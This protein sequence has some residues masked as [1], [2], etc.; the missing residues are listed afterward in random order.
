LGATAPV[1]RASARQRIALDALTPKRAAARRHDIPPSTAAITR[2]RKS[3]DGA[4]AMPVGLP[5]RQAA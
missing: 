2:S 4:F 1:S 3:A 5:R